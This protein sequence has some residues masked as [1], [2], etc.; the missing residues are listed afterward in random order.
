MCNTTVHP[1]A[2]GAGS[3]HS[4]SS[5]SSQQSHSHSY[6]HES[7]G[8]LVSITVRKEN[9]NDKAGIQ[10][11]QDKYG[12]VHVTNIAKNGLFGN[13]QLEIGDTILSVNRRRLSKGEGPKEILRAVHKYKTISISIRKAPPKGAPLVGRKKDKKKN[14]EKDNNRAKID[15][16]YRG[17]SKY[18]EDG[19]INVQ[20]DEDSADDEKKMPTITISAQ[21]GCPSN[22][23]NEE[24][25]PGNRRTSSSSRSTTPKKRRSL[26]SEVGLVGLELA[27]EGKNRLVV[28]E[29]QPKSIFR[30]TKLRVGDRILSINDMS[31]RQYIDAEYAQSVMDNAPFMVTLV[32]E[33]PELRRGSRKKEELDHS[34]GQSDEDEFGRDTPLSKYELKIE[35]DF[36]IETYRPATITAP[37]SRRSQ[38]SGL[39]F[40]LVRTTR[41]FGKDKK[42]SS[43]MRKKKATWVYVDKIDPDSLFAKTSLEVGDKIISINNIDLRH[44]PDPNLAYLTCSRSTESIALVVL[45]DEKVFKEKKLCFDKSITNLEWKV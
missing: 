45:K 7:T 19:S 32:I 42:G 11:E 17:C 18:K 27:A 37:K 16:Y 28:R 10:L 9:P 24:S 43:A 2:V 13:S 36:L 30:G 6:S 34:E 41:P 3:T 44:T 20:Y 39:T 35:T 31:F 8:K 26:P 33:K 23:T 22:C 21:K 15:T 4:A 5:T 14:Q 25:K 40:K 29:I 12:T 38:D 1:P